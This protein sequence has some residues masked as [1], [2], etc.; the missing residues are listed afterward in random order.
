MLSSVVGSGTVGP[1]ASADSWP[2][3]TSLIA[4][5][6]FIALGAAAERRPPFVAER[7]LRTTLISSMGAPQVTSAE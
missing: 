1:D 2:S 5:V 3:G 7:C 4:K 6:S